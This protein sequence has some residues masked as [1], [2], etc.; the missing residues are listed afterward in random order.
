M[1]NVTL[2]SLFTK[3]YLSQAKVMIDSYINANK[4]AK[5]HILALDQDT[6]DVLSLIYV[7]K[8]FVTNLESNEYL[9][10][11]FRR[12]QDTRNFA[13]TIFTLK[14]IWIYHLAKTQDA[15]SIILYADADLYFF[16]EIKELQETGWSVLLSPHFFAERL[17][18]LKN[19]GEY[20]AGLIGFRVDDEALKV[21]SW[22]QQ[23]VIE[24]CSLS[25]QIGQ[26]ADQKYLENFSQISYS[27]QTFTDPGVNVG[28]WRLARNMDVRKKGTSTYLQGYKILAFHFHSFKIYQRSFYT[29]IYRYGFNLPSLL[30]FLFVYLQ[31]I[32]K[33]EKAY[34]FILDFHVQ[35][36]LRSRNQLLVIK[37]IL[38]RPLGLLDLWPHKNFSGKGMN[39]IQ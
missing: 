35:P 13:E 17:T 7:D 1:S 38:R 16:E 34:M 6:Y 31:Y 30:I 8:V 25:K 15:G 27:V 37:E 23:S 2:T 32:K 39:P 24:N 3:E 20:N 22:W 11:E 14:A 21:L 28:A 36:S 4:F 26:Y 19:S 29:G 12:L 9:Q 33:I 5:I 10:A 18:Y